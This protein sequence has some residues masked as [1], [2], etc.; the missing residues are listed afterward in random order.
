MATVRI[1]TSRTTGQVAIG[2]WLGPYQVAFELAR[3]GMASIY[4][5]RTGARAGL[6]RF[7]A[8]KCIRSELARDP[9]FVAMFFDEAHIASQIQHPNVC[10][11]LDFDAHQDVYF[12]A[13]ELLSGQTLNRLC[14][15]L[16]EAPHPRGPLF[17]AGLVCRLL[18]DACE[19]LHASHELLN[20]H[21][22]PLNIV[23][24]DVAPD[25]LFV[26]YDG[27]LKVLDFG[28]ASAS[29]QHHKTQTGMIRGK[30][31]YL[32]PEVVKGKKPDRRAD[33]WGLGVTAWEMLTHKKLFKGE[34]DMETFRAI[35]GTTIHPPST[36]CAGL[37]PELDEIVLRAL[38]RKVDA[39]WSTA[40]EMGQALTAFLTEHELA[41]GLPEI[42]QTVNALF[43]EG[44][45]LTRKLFE[46]A[47]QLPD[48]PPQPIEL[49]AQQFQL[50]AEPPKEPPP[51]PPRRRAVAPL[52]VAACSLVLAG[53]ALAVSLL[54]RW[55]PQP[56]REAVRVEPV[57]LE[58]TAPARS[59]QP[60]QPPFGVEMIPLQADGSGDV[61]LRLR[62]TSR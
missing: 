9:G 12:L 37:P 26:T 46:A 60:A 36:A 54:S 24:R 43:P 22:E 19:G 25:N 20:A 2:S 45:L 3:G 55:L 1:P 56:S 47:E 14:H 5:A 17:Q 6:H 33:V 41:I 48:R 61:L 35:C 34:T 11:V 44:R 18:A 4:L 16:R 53:A 32:A 21:G 58:T 59:P 8:L 15:R 13:L 28:V 52:V 50:V 23:H 39:R 62:V 57:R 27:N 30:C 29:Q 51:L 10:G 42:S 49:S 7:V 38:D 40:R 31:S